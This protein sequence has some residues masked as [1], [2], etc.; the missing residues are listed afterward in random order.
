[1]SRD[2]HPTARRYDNLAGGADELRKERR[3]R[4]ECQYC[5]YVAGHHPNCPEYVDPTDYR[6]PDTIAE[7]EGER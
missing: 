5:G 3:E 4:G 1:M 6:G 7:A 2:D